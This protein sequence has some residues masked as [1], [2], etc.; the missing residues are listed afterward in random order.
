MQD[1]VS[2][3]L[4]IS[5]V[6]Y[7]FVLFIVYVIPIVRLLYDYFYRIES[8]K[9]EERVD[10]RGLPTSKKQRRCTIY[11]QSE[12]AGCKRR[13]KICYDTTNETYDH[14]LQYCSIN[15]FWF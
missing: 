2:P 6:L 10:S 1:S 13:N 15:G 8:K 12:E 4:A 3:A 5:S 14:R 7:S 11:G 9:K